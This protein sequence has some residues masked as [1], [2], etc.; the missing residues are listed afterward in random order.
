MVEIKCHMTFIAEEIELR[1]APKVNQAIDILSKLRSRASL[2]ILKMTYPLFCS[3][4][5]YRPQLGNQSIITSQNKIQK[6]QNIALGKI[7]FKK[8][9]VSIHQIYKELKILKLCN[10]LLYL[11][12]CLFLS[13]I[14]KN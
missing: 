10:R 1:V 8:Q 14:E 4:L 6:L 12:N 5:L 3:H 7:L 2:K 9:Q 11:Q 13:Q